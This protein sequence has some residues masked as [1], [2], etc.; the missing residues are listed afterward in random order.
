MLEK[1][2]R[3]LDR[4]GGRIESWPESEA[5]TAYSDRDPEAARALDQARRLERV[6]DSWHA[7]EPPPG[8]RGRLASIPAMERAQRTSS[9]S[10][11]LRVFLG[12]LGW[13]AATGMAV[14][15]ITGIAVGLSSFG[16]GALDLAMG[17]PVA[18]IESEA[19]ALA[20]D[21]TGDFDS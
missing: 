6:L 12:G 11:A 13:R 9:W 4:R 15:L 10:V 7:P 16:S 2:L 14:A 18:G 17:D 20:M 5:A 8:L 1:F 21:L 3:L 19:I